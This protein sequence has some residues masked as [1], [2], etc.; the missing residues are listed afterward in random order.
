MK[1][2][3]I[4]A[5]DKELD[6]LLPHIQNKEIRVAD[7]F[8]MYYGTMG[9]N[10]ICAM[11][12]GIGKVNA[13][14]GCLAMIHEI[15]PQI[16]I[17]TGVAGGTGAARVLDLAVATGV[18]YHDV[19]CGPDCSYGRVSGC[20]ALFKADERVIA[21][22]ALKNDPHIKFGTI[23]SGDIFVDSRETVDKVLRL[24]PDAIGVDMESGAI[25]Q[26][27][28]KYGVPFVIVRVISDTP[29]EVADNGAQY[30]SF[31]E[32]APRE[33]FALICEIISKL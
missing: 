15:T 11:T 24:Y 5:M 6:L 19:Y 1:V 28:H 13:A 20:P 25:A 3:I 8:K 30:F 7:G 16:I 17:N 22:L 31:W 32:E 14:L 26:T 21:M 27:C 18:G 10:E 2:G 12:C 23:A 4:V 33:T 9:S 29:G